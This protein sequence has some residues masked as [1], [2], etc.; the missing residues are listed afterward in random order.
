MSA[1]WAELFASYSRDD[2]TDIRT[3]GAI[4][5]RLAN[6]LIR[7]VLVVTA[8]FFRDMSSHDMPS[9]ADA[10]YSFPF[11]FALSTYVLALHW[12]VKGGCRNAAARTIRNDFT[13]AT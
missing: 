5:A 1:A 7:D 13:D 12:A 2:L 6:R 3:Q 9:T 10:V 11:R 8:R 4:S